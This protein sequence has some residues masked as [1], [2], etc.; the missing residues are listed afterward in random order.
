MNT[1]CGAVLFCASAVSAQTPVLQSTTRVNPPNPPGPNAVPYRETAI[2]VAPGPTD[3]SRVQMVASAIGFGIEYGFSF[4]SGTTFPTTGTLQPAHG[5]GVMPSFDP[6]V[7]SSSSGELWLGGQEDA[8]AFPWKGFVLSRK[9]RTQSNLDPAASVSMICQFGGGGFYDKALS[10][11]GPDS[12]GQPTLHLL[13]TRS[14]NSTGCNYGIHWMQAGAVPEVDSTWNSLDQRLVAPPSVGNICPG[15][16]HGAFPVVVPSGP[17]AG[18][19]VVAFTPMATSNYPIAAFV[20][21][22]SVTW[23]DWTSGQWQAR[24]DLVQMTVD[25]ASRILPLSD[26]DVPGSFPIRAFP[27]MAV[28]PTNASSV[29][30]TFAGTVDASVPDRNLDLFIARSTDGGSS[31]GF[32]NR[33]RVTD[34]MLGDG[35]GTDQ[36]MPSIWVDGFG[37]VNLLYYRVGVPTTDSDMFP[38]VQ[39]MYARFAQFQGPLTANPSVIPLSPLFQPPTTLGG[40]HMGDYCMIAGTGC[41]LFPCFIST[42]EGSSNFYVS[43][44]SLCKADVD[45]DGYVNPPADANQFASAFINAQ[46]AADIDGNGVIDASDVVLVQQALTCGC[47]LPPPPHP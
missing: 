38:F 15:D 30:I 23:Y 10:A 18:R 36:F 6:F 27:S 22:P 34:S 43:R 33:L 9:G 4:N 24:V 29:Y 16:G 19:L 20:N 42:H 47:E 26:D 41:L 7:A 3:G 39:A 32:S 17:F 28:D 14:P 8:G 44:I 5:C 45:S 12:A 40:Q 13:Y 37:G 11:W 1:R 35:A 21:P 25:P 31:F 2:A 46:P